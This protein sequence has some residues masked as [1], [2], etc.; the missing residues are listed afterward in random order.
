[1]SILLQTP[2]L[3]KMKH[4]EAEKLL[5]KHFIVG[6]TFDGGVVFARHYNSRFHKKLH[7]FKI[8][9]RATVAFIGNPNDIGLVS[10]YVDA[11]ADNLAD[12]IGE[13]V[14]FCYLTNHYI[15]NCIHS[16]L[17]DKF[18][19]DISPFGIK[20]VVVQSENRFAV[21]NYSGQVKNF[22]KFVVA[23]GELAQGKEDAVKFLSGLNFFKGKKLPTLVEASNAI[24][25]TLFN[26]DI[27]PESKE[28]E[29]IFI[30][31]GEIKSKIF[32]K[33]SSKVPAK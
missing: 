9:G 4:C 17:E 7:W 11:S 12:I 24:K 20:A 22:S 26:F 29:S 1:M 3:I 28:Y 31:K 30:T 13:G 25:N 21:I 14:R 6:V 5:G 15:K 8:F 33:K 32:S 18:K 23:G 2:E 27:E 10:N 16:V 19:S